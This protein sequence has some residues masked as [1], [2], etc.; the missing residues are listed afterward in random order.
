[1]VE[2]SGRAADLLAFTYKYAADEADES[3]S[4]STLMDGMREQLIATIQ[5]TFAVDHF[6]AEKLLQQQKQLWSI[7]RECKNTATEIIV[8]ESISQKLILIY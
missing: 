7:R 3:T 1:M 8:K 5:R 2:G 4:A 6:Q